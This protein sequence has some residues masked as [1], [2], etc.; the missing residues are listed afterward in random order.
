MMRSGTGGTEMQI[1]GERPAGQMLAR[2]HGARCT[3]Y[4]N[5]S[6][7][8]MCTMICGKFMWVLATEMSNYNLEWANQ[9]ISS[10]NLI[11]MLSSSPHRVNQRL[12]NALWKRVTRPQ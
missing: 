6:L 3:Q 12:H 9:I 11:R 7:F 5:R 2:C 1:F 8:Q 10:T 4:V